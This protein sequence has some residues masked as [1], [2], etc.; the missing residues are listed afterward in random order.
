MPHAPPL[1]PVDGA[2]NCDCYSVRKVWLSMVYHFLSTIACRYRNPIQNTLGCTM[3]AL[4]C[5]Q[6]T[7]LIILPHSGTDGLPEK[8]TE[9]LTLG[10]TAPCQRYVQLERIPCL[11]QSMYLFS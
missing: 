6:F 1:S 8:N 11:I 4:L 3:R 9:R 5:F 10:W 7:N 2:G